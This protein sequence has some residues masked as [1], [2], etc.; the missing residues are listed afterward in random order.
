M[1]WRSVSLEVVESD[2]PVSRQPLLVSGQ[3]WMGWLIGSVFAIWFPILVVG[4]LVSW[5]SGRQLD[6][7]TMVILL[8]GALEL[9]FVGSYVFSLRVS[10][11]AD[12]IVLRNW[13]WRSEARWEDLT[14]V[15]SV[16]W[17]ARLGVPAASLLRRGRS[18]LHLCP[19]FAAQRELVRL[20][21]VHMLMAN[22]DAS[23]DRVLL[24]R[25]GAEANR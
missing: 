18:P 16:A 22:P 20:V 17:L 9:A 21:T 24:A 25:L 5:W 23:V 19:P 1:G 14:R 7:A 11:F 3:G 15:K 6:F 13:W 2:R 8:L 4:M 10:V 12:R